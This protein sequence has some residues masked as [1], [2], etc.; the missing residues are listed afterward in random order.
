MQSCSKIE[1]YVEHVA[2]IIRTSLKKEITPETNLKDLN[3]KIDKCVID[4]LSRVIDF[5]VF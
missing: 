1:A 5:S 2:E 4:Q 3:R